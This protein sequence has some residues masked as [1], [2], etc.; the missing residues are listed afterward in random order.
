MNVPHE[1]IES[2]VKTM[3]TTPGIITALCDADN[4]A[5][6]GEALTLRDWFTVAELEEMK[7][8]E[9]FD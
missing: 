1:V 9:E 3:T 4:Y 6:Y 8:K 2:E 5:K 7:R